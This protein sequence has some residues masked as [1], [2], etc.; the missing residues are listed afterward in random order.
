MLSLAAYASHY[1]PL[2][3][4][5]RRQVWPPDAARLRET[6][7]DTKEVKD[8]IRMLH[9]DNEEDKE[10][11]L[12]MSARQEETYPAESSV[13]REKPNDERVDRKEPIDMVR[14]VS[15][16]DE[17]FQNKYG[18]LWPDADASDASD[19]KDES[20]SKDITRL[21]NKMDHVINLI[22]DDS[23]SFVTEELILYCFLGIFVIFLVDAF[24]NAG[25]VYHR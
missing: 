24:L 25:R 18:P 23:S 9:A 13:S 19:M 15:G 20:K 22:E 5:N 4:N 6:P 14:E 17:G 11:N 8:I 3:A 12:P 16:I 7:E 21:L 2:T 10:F 1:E